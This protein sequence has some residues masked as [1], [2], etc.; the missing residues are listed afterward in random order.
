MEKAF[1]DTDRET[2]YNDIRLSARIGVV[3]RWKV[4][5]ERDIADLACEIGLIQEEK[6]RLQRCIHALDLV[7]SINKEIKQVRC[8]RME[9]DLVR[10]QVEEEVIEVY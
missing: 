4:E 7:E 1:V 10:D 9:P 8:S 2:L 5:L 6:I 3:F